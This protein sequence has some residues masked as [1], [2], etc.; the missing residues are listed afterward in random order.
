[1]HTCG[2]Y[3]SNPDLVYIYRKASIDDSA[4]VDY[5]PAVLVYH[6]IDLKVLFILLGGW[7]TIQGQ[8][9]L[10]LYMYNYP[11]Q[12]WKVTAN[13]CSLLTAHGK[14]SFVQFSS[15]LLLLTMLWAWSLTRPT[16]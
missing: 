7:V 4:Q 12:S 15:H 1:M 8:S 13:I 10:W 3:I 14:I 6:H 5:V 11:S 16:Y 9:R 2:V